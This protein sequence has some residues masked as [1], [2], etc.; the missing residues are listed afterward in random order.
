MDRIEYD[1][2]GLFHE[3]ASEFGLPYDGPPSV[4]REF[5]EVEPGRRLS[6][7]V[8]GTEEPDLV[9]IHGGSQNAHTWDTVALALGRPLVAIDLPGHGHSD[10]PGEPQ[11]D[12]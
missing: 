5:V 6:A 9:L 2:F 8:W 7:I 1:E 10:G 11:P 4:R 12:S 3:N